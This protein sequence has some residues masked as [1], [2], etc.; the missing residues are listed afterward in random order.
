MEFND[1]QKRIILTEF[2][3]YMGITTQELEKLIKPEAK[4]LAGN[5]GFKEF[6]GKLNELSVLIME[7]IMEQKEQEEQKE[8]KEQEEQK[9]GDER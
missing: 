8:Q 2:K 3:N 9:S 5:A 4:H 7:T 6:D 1:E